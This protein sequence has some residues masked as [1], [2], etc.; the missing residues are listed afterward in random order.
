[1]FAGQLYLRDWDAYLRLTDSLDPPKKARE[2]EAG[3]TNWYKLPCPGSRKELEEAHPD[4]LSP[5]V[6]MLLA[7]RRR[8][9]PFGET[10]MGK[11]LQG[12]ALTEEDFIG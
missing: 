10:H 7:I 1:M 6:M 12:Q 8:G 3:R 4:S 11:I 2:D 9:L 5:S